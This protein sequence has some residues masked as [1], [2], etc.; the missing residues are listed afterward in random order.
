[1]TIQFNCPNCGELIAFADKHGGKRAHCTTCGQRFVIPLPGDKEAKKVKPP[2]E[3]K[4]Q[5]I[6]IPGFYRA[7]F[8]ESWK[9]FTDS[10]N[11]TA[12]AFILVLV[13]FKFFTAR[14]NFK[15]FIQ[16]NW[17]AF[18]FYV[19]LGWASSGG[20]W[21]C[22]FWLY[23]EMIY[24]VGFDQDE[25]PILTTGGFYGLIWIILKSLY[26]IAIILLVVGLPCII[27]FLA[28][29]Y[30]RAESPMLLSALGFSALFLIPIAILTVAVGKDLTML[31]PDYL[32]APILRAF[33]PYLVLVIWLCLAAGLQMYASQYAGQSPKIAAGHLLLNLVVQALALITARSIGLFYR[34]YSCHLPW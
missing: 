5:A 30:M 4:E 34:H 15:F 26:S 27:A 23:T 3:E 20:A 19:P 21:G 8:I 18:D 25:L 28:L 31:R 29:K 9:L 10:K 6:P 24:A 7:V 1:M 22:L 32:L 16:G 2:K 11:V 12:F 17:L 33:R 14:L 13:I